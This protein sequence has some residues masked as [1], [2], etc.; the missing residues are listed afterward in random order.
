M[1]GPTYSN[2]ITLVSDV[3]AVLK[4][5]VETNTKIEVNNENVKDRT[6]LLSSTCQK[7]VTIEKLE[8]K[9]SF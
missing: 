2:V 1:N 8:R 3:G 6:S 5:V 4:A 9:N 7:K